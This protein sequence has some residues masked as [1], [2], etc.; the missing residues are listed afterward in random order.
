MIILP[1]NG[2]IIGIMETV[3][4]SV[5][6]V[7]NSSTQ[8][9]KTLKTAIELF[10]ATTMVD[11]CA[12]EPDSEE[13]SIERSPHWVENCITL[14]TATKPMLLNL[15]GAKEE[16][17]VVWEE[18]LDMQELITRT[19]T[20]PILLILDLWLAITKHTADATKIVM[21]AVLLQIVRTVEE[22]VKTEVIR[23][24]KMATKEGVARVEN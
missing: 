17:S 19:I 2:D 16:V 3:D 21:I 5:E 10:M 6:L 24:G 18:D 15:A 14:A 22:R 8:L 7:E 11:S 1:R 12:E 9:E 4:F 20:M 13:D 23:E